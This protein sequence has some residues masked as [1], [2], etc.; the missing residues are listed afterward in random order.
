MNRFYYPG[1]VQNLVAGALTVMIYPTSQHRLPQEKLI[2][3]EQTDGN[4]E[5]KRS[6][7]CY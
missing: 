5:T 2:L 3:A 7:K 1:F 4:G 6:G